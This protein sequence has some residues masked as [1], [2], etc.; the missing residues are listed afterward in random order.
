MFTNLLVE[1]ATNVIFVLLELFFCLN[2]VFNFVDGGNFANHVVSKL[3]RS[4]RI[5]LAFLAKQKHHWHLK[6]SLK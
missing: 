3:K 6:I 5:R 2:F 4:L 1:L